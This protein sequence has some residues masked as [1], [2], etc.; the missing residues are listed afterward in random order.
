MEDCLWAHI[1]HHTHERS[2]CELR[3]ELISRLESVLVSLEF[4]P[5]VVESEQS[6]PEERD[7]QE[8]DIDVA[9]FSEEQDRHEDGEDDDHSTHRRHPFLLDSIRVDFLIACFLDVSFP[10]HVG[11]ELLA[12]PKRQDE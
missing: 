10:L 4:F 5:V 8:D 12:E 3:H 6:E 1:E 2:E 7:E 9:E 11:D